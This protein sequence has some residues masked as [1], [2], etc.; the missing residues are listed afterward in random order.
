MVIKR[1]S[2]K[3]LIGTKT[4]TPVGVKSHTFIIL[5]SQQWSQNEHKL[6]SSLKNV[7]DKSRTET[8]SY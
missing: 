4:N 8:S 7:L 5:A 1:V 3:V 2:K 6:I